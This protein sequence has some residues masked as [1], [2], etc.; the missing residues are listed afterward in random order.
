MRRDVLRRLQQLRLM[1]FDVDGVLTDGTLYLSDNGAEIKA[2]NAHDGHGLK[3]LRES[4]LEVAL[5]SA[6]HS[7]AV[8]LRAAELGIGLLEQSASDKEAAFEQLLA[9]VKV[10]PPAA[11]YMGD[12][13][14]DLPV[15]VRCGFAASVPEAPDAVRR[16]VHHVT[17]APAGRGAAR[18]VCEL[19]MQ[20][21]DTLERAISRQL[22]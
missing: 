11:G 7:R 16:R 8:E 20:A 19:I 12:D 15:L 10:S 18:E 13:L 14:A 17:R 2:F 4:G 21:Q 3:M 5:L 6:R 9:R 22:A 1:V